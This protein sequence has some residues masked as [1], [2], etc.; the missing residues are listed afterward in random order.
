MK[1]LAHPIA[2]L[3]FAAGLSLAAASAHATQVVLSDPLTQWPLN[4][5]AQ[6]DHVMMKDG[7]VHIIVSGSG[8]GSEIYPGFTFKDMDASVTIT[9]KTQTGNAA[10]LLFWVSQPGDFYVFSVSDS[11]GAL[12]V[13]HHV[14]ANGGTWETVVPFTKDPNIRSGRNAANTLRV[15]TNGNSIS[16]FINGTAVGRLAAIAPQDGGTVGIEGEGKAGG[17][18]DYAFSNLSVSQ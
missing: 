6:T 5:G 15:V 11:S 17:R 7:Q 10:G 2:C 1:L 18:A 14:P 13:V 16:L 12:G 3:S 4:F 9:A 8:A